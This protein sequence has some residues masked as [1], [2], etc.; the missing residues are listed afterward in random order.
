AGARGEIPYRLVPGQD[1]PFADLS[2]PAG[3]F[4][5]LDYSES[6]PLLFLGR[7][8]TLDELGIPPGQRRPVPG[9][10]PRVAAVRP[11]CPPCGAALALRAPDRSERVGCPSCGALLDVHE[12]K[13]RLLESLKPPKVQPV[14]PLGATGKHA[15]AEWTA[16][17]FLRRAVTLGGQDYFWEEYLL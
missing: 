4:G 16:L 1:H 9:E 7:E 12:G 3:A 8:V 11:T 17:G 10:G 15:G 14:I 6:P 5:T 13:L 2:G